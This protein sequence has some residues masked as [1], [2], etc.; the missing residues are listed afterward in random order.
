M[1]TTHK[2]VRKA[3]LTQ[4][5]LSAKVGLTP[6][7]ISYILSGQRDPSLTLAHAIAKELKVSLDQL[8]RSIHPPKPQEKKP[9]RT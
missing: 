1:Q 5:Q 7:A 2:M 9:S 8:Y 4:A 3:G 6:A